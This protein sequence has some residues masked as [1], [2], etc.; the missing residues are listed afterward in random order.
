MATETRQQWL[1]EEQVNALLIV[2]GYM[3][4][5]V[6]AEAI[7]ARASMTIGVILH[8]LVMNGLV[9]Q[10]SRTRSQPVRRLLMA[11]LLVPLVRLLSVA[12]P[13]ENFNVVYWYSMVGIPLAIASLLVMNAS[14]YLPDNVGLTLQK[15]PIQ[16]VVAASGVIVGYIHFLILDVPAAILD[17]DNVI[18]LGTLIVSFLVFTGIV[19]ELVFR[20]I[21][22][23]TLVEN[24]GRLAGIAV[25]VVLSSLLYFSYDQ[26]L[27]LVAVIV[28]HLFFAVVYDR[29]GSIVGIGIAH[30]LAN[31]LMYVYLPTIL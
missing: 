12:I 21:L 19:E 10:Y 17:L 30:G 8:I 14:G 27:H 24:V 15:W 7:L 22:Q 18:Q 26:P 13:L 4:A 6:V 20:G 2:T 16:I 25:S 29:T 31:V 3:V 11:V 28:T 9:F 1:S 23:T 5:L